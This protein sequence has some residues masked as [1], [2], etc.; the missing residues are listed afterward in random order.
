MEGRWQRGQREY[1]YARSG[2][3]SLGYEGWRTFSRVG[4]MCGLTQLRGKKL[5]TTVRK[6]CSSGMGYLMKVWLPIFPLLAVLAA[7]TNLFGCS[8][9]V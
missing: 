8:L 4:T 6:R 9:L 5:A 2:T 7:V 3:I 1:Q